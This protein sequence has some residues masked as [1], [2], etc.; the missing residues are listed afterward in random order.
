MKL[1]AALCILF[2][3]SSMGHSQEISCPE[4]FY[5]NHRSYY[6]NQG[7]TLSVN[8][9]I[10]PSYDFK[11]PILSG[12]AIV[13]GES[14]QAPKF[15]YKTASG[16]VTQVWDV[17]E[18]PHSISCI[19]YAIHAALSRDLDRSTQLCVLTE[20]TSSDGTHPSLTGACK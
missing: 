19:Y 16:N 14:Q 7:W 6:Q 9:D 15:N 20:S 13:S 3:A 5:M 8:K 17:T 11:F 10:Y 2:N 18:G 12:L 4:I 1:V